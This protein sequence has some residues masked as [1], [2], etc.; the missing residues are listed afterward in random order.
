MIKI[1]KFSFEIE[2]SSGGTMMAFEVSVN[3]KGELDVTKLQDCSLAD[4]DGDY[5]FNTDNQLFR[6]QCDVEWE[7]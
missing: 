4:V 2:N 7:Q 1:K 6:I 3:E 5:I